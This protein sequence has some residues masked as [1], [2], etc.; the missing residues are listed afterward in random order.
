M[1]VRNEPDGRNGRRAAGA[2]A[3]MLIVLVASGC[4][5]FNRTVRETPAELAER[6]ATEERIALA[7]A[8]RIAAEP[9]LEG[10]RVRVAVDGTEVALYGSV[11]GL[12]PLS[13]AISNAQLVPGVTLVIDHMV[14]DPGP[15]EAPC[16]A[17]R[18]FVVPV[19]VLP[20]K[21]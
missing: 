3:T 9:A 8:A 12:G 1:R 7:V 5:V 11:P 4:S 18:L 21:T 10:A 15:P 19:P 16:V 20:V 6:T 13:C 17:P 2:V 14:L